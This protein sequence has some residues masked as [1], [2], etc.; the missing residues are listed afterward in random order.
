MVVDQVMEELNLEVP[1]LP[2][3]EDLEEMGL[4]EILIVQVEAVEGT[5]SGNA[6]SENSAA[7]NGGN[8]VA[9]TIA[10]SSVTRGGGGGG[11]GKSGGSTNGGSGGSGGGGNGSTNVQVPT[12]ELQT[13]VADQEHTVWWPWRWIWCCNN[14]IAAANYSGSATG[15]Q[16]LQ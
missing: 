13:L 16:L 3:K 6:G 1:E 9:S 2:I 8:G 10:G 15:S 7:G 5:N 12:Q 4:E 14:K 11:G